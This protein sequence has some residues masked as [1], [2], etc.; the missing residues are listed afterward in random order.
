MRR[1][2]V[3]LGLGV[4][5]I[6]VLVMLMS[7]C[8]PGGESPTP[9][10][11]PEPR[12][13]TAEGSVVPA[14]WAHLAF[15]AGGRVAHIAVEEGDQVEAGKL[16]ARLDAADQEL[17]VE[18]AEASLTLA[19]ASLD[20]LLAGSR[21]ED[22]AIAEANVKS[23]EAQLRALEIGPTVDAIAAAEKLVEQAKNNLWASQEW[24]DAVC[25]NE[26]KYDRSTSC[27]AEEARVGA[28]HSAIEMAQ[29]QLR[30]LTAPP[31]A[32]ELDQAKA[33]A[34]VAQQRLRLAQSPYRQQ[35][36]AVARA[37]VR[38]AQVAL[39]LARQAMT[40][41][42]ISAPY[43]GTV[44]E[45]LVREG[46]M[47]APNTPAI[48]FGD[49]TRLHIETTDLDETDAAKVKVG[50]RVEVTTYALEDE[51]FKGKVIAIA[52]AGTK[53]SSGD[54][55]YT[56]TIALDE[57]APELRWRMTTKVEFPEATW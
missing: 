3:V 23:A 2:L 6:V 28:A 52:P 51:V 20:Q 30:D 26:W 49:L 17:Q 39:D 46:E 37:K 18:A 35:D 10:P 32:E 1:W 33:T 56:V 13:V 12:P 55:N 45:V 47:V 15:K 43:A 50:Q 29:A 4:V 7:V 21:G 54:V 24:R 11:T 36:L 44:A 40:D 16:V 31:T 9:V 38:Q 14:S 48:L 5:A 22:I 57:A 8:N 27:D 42:L 34:A 19:Q 41:T 25:G 53:T